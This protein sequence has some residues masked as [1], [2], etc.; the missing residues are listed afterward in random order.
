MSVDTDPN[1]I[2]ETFQSYR[3]S[4]VALIFYLFVSLIAINTPNL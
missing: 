4:A 2:Q 3:L 1:P